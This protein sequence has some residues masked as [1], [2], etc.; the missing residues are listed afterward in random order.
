MA[1]PNRKFQIGERKQTRR[2]AHARRNCLVRSRAVRLSALC[3]LWGRAPQ[4]FI[5]PSSELDVDHV[6][7]VGRSDDKWVRHQV[8]L[9]VSD[10]VR[11]SEYGPCFWCGTG[12][13]RTHKTLAG[14]L[15]QLFLV[16]ARA[17]CHLLLYRPQRWLF[18]GTTYVYSCLQ[19]PTVSASA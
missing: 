2:S 15:C 11:A 19:P 7:N 17:L 8:P 16:C 10:K 5:S 1:C 18:A 9:V 13:L 3:A 4:P 6:L 12:L 14:T